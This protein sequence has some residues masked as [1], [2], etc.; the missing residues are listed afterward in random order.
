MVRRGYGLTWHDPETG[1]ELPERRVVFLTAGSLGFVWQG[2]KETTA[3][4]P[5]A[6]TFLYEGD[7]GA[8]YWL[9]YVPGRKHSIEVWIQG[10]F[11]SRAKMTVESLVNT[12]LGEDGH[13]ALMK[14]VLERFILVETRSQQATDGIPKRE[15]LTP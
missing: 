5:A 1:A 13:G 14:R 2:E 3:E 10:F 4:Y 11:R 9:A 12:N 6:S 8:D 15:R 7:S